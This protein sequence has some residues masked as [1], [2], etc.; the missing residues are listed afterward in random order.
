MDSGSESSEAEAWVDFED[1]VFDWDRNEKYR[2]AIEITVQKA[3][4]EQ[5]RADVLDIGSGSGLLSFYSAKADADSV[6]A[7]EMD[8]VIFGTSRD[9]AQRNNLTEKIQFINRISTEYESTFKFNVLVSEMVDSELIGENLITTYRHALKELLSA[10]VLAVPAKAN[11]Y[12]VP[13]ESDFLRR[14]S[15]IPS[16]IREECVGNQRG[17]E[18]QWSE[19]SDDL[20]RGAEKTLVKSFDLAS[21]QSLAESESISLRIEIT[22]DMVSQIDGVLFFWELDMTGDGSIIISTEPGNSAWR[23][24][25]L[26][27]LFP[28]ND[29]IMVRQYDFIQITASHDLVS[30]WFEADFDS[31]SL[32]KTLRIRRECS[33]D[34][35][36]IVSPLTINRWNHYEGMDFTETAI[37]LSLEKSILVL[38]SHST[39]SLHLIH[40]ANIIYHVD[41]DFRFRQKFQNSTGKL[42]S[43]RI[44]MVD[45]T[46]KVPLDQVEL[47]VFDV[48]S[49]PT[50]SPMEFVKI[51]KKIREDA[52]NIRIFPENLHLQA[53]QIKLGD[54]SKRRSNYTKVDEF[55]YTDFVELSR[56]LPIVF[57]HHLELL[58]IW[59]YENTI[60][61]T[62]KI[63]DLIGEER[64]TEIDLKL[65]DKTDAIIFWWATGELQKDMSTNLDVDDK[66]IRWRR[67]S[68]Q[69]IHFRRDD[70]AKN[71]NIQFDLKKWR[72]RIEEISI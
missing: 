47:I 7:L 45:S 59:E 64:P 40:S 31:N 33:C 12:I 10:K 21:L 44:K 43:N 15:V 1:M 50:V 54:L 63:F 22:N 65:D 58:P 34:W 69:W 56:P 3:K 49:D 17:L 62:T 27:M 13:V 53:S 52:P 24:H 16:Q 38:G 8:P 66:K 18:G 6:T 32:G 48:N 26:P 67:G 39:L 72:F 30:F 20:I 71:L 11:V 2:K 70:L 19:L 25:W 60:I 28:F 51:L 9:I 23:N 61:S 37:Q 29:P 41:S 5:H 46:D 36:S 57:D 14:S 42:C 68:Q 35:H 55:D 4:N